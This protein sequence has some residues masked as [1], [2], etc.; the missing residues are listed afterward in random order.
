MG[1]VLHPCELQ[2]KQRGEREEGKEA[3]GSP[4]LL[5]SH[6][7][8]RKGIQQAAPSH[9]RRWRQPAS[10]EAYRYSQH[11]YIR[12]VFFP[13]K[14]QLLAYRH[15]NNHI[16]SPSH[17]EEMQTTSLQVEEKNR[18]GSSSNNPEASGETMLKPSS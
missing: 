11:I 17:G 7:T 10:S 15:S 14:V 16:F 9:P 8:R 12:V 4:R 13:L 2:I 6:A 1:K 3:T 18:L 5:P